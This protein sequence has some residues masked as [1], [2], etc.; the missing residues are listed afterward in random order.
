MSGSSDS[1]DTDKVQRFAEAAQAERS[2]LVGEV[3]HY[4]KLY[5]R[6]SIIPI[7]LALAL[8]GAFL[9]LGSSGVAP[10]IYALF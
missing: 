9:S 5:R 2:S 7:L 10:F 4:V 1:Q 6:W 3:V 8:L